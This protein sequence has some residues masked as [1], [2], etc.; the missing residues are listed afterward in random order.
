M[1]SF[2][3]STEIHVDMRSGVCMCEHACILYFAC[4]YVC[5]H[6]WASMMDMCVSECTKPALYC[7]CDHP[8]DI[9]Q[10]V[11]TCV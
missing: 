7:L 4:A 5:D 9:C 11:I 8:I 3:L 10:C 1:F 2:I 6:P